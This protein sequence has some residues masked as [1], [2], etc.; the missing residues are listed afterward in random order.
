MLFRS[1]T[2]MQYG[3]TM[4]I[5]TLKDILSLSLAIPLILQGAISLD[6]NSYPNLFTLNSSTEHPRWRD[7]QRE[8]L[9]PYTDLCH[10]SRLCNATVL[11]LT[12][13]EQYT[14][15]VCEVCFCDDLC[16][17]YGDC[18]LDKVLEDT[19]MDKYVN[20]TEPQREPY[21]V[22][23]ADLR[24]KGVQ[25]DEID[26]LAKQRLIF[27]C[28]ENF[29]N[30]SLRS[31]CE[32][33]GAINKNL[34]SLAISSD[35]LTHN[36]PVASTRSRLFYKNRACALCHD[37]AE[38]DTLVP[39]SLKLSCEKSLNIPVSADPFTVLT[40]FLREP[41]CEAV[42]TNPDGIEPRKCA[43]PRDPN[44]KI[45]DQCNTTGKRSVYDDLLWR[46]CNVLSMFIKSYE[47]AY[48][49]PFCLR[50]QTDWM[51]VIRP[52][53]QYSGSVPFF[54]VLSP[55][56]MES[57]QRV[58]ASYDCRCRNGYIYNP[59]KISSELKKAVLGELEQEYN[60]IDVK[61][62]LVHVQ[63]V[64]EIRQNFTAN[65]YAEID[66][67][68][69]KKQEHFEQ[70]LLSLCNQSWIVT[71]PGVN[72]SVSLEPS[73][74]IR[75]NKTFLNSFT[76]D[77][78]LISTKFDDTGL[79]RTEYY[80][81]FPEPVPVAQ[82]GFFA[83]VEEEETIVYTE[84]KN[85][86]MCPHFIYDL[87]N[88]TEIKLERENDFQWPHSND[89]LL[90]L[91][92]GLKL[93][94]NDFSYTDNGLVILC[95]DHITEKM[96]L[97][98]EEDMEDI[99]GIDTFGS[100]LVL[101]SHICLGVSSLCLALTFITYCLFPVLRTLPGKSTMCL[102]LALL[103][104]IGLF[105]SGGFVQASSV[106][107]QIIGVATHFFLLS[108][109]VWMLLCSAHMYSVFSHV[110]EQSAATKSE[111]VSRFRAYI[112]L[113]IAMPASIVLTTVMSN[114]F[115]TDSSPTINTQRVDNIEIDPEETES[116]TNSCDSPSKVRIGY[117]HGICYL[118]NKLSLLLA[119]ALPIAVICA[120][121]LAIFILTLA[122]F[123]R[124]SA[125]EKVARHETRCHLLIYLKLSTLTGINWLP[126]TV[127]A[128]VSSPVVWYSFLIF[129]GLQGLY[130]FL[131]FVCNK[132]VLGLYKQLFTSR[133]NGSVPS[134]KDTK[135]G[136]HAKTQSHEK[137]M[138]AAPCDSKTTNDQETNEQT[139]NSRA[140]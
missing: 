27:K 43:F 101:T 139:H 124:M 98:Y 48:T 107:C 41:T 50:C 49:N 64:T 32:D 109:F 89:I 1:R 37:D 6:I 73:I 71:L 59:Y 131:S 29:G 39:W 45:I 33:F 68:Y 87:K 135:D 95:V 105:I 21:Y 10:K 96:K 61:F 70:R 18:C 2:T 54:I 111:T 38:E 24:V 22:E 108:T 115:L 137:Y 74:Q 46:S 55:D 63:Q 106:E 14:C 30:Q 79:N 47:A 72:E 80:F 94:A 97:D 36:W 40:M 12:S 35:Q 129:C 23:C 7:V 4:H 114:Y 128:F 103:L 66:V 140:E 53:C 130:V 90:H 57:T 82:W 81:L 138:K 20:E 116:V 17:R 34:Y 84:V 69:N 88:S 51:K 65:F 75:P 56:A 117:G 110:M 83:D 78:V 44:L 28:P 86:L 113:S 25:G 92:T 112:A 8:I 85:T 122:A 93:S 5:C 52:S 119:G 121:N 31:E 91:E 133:E 13:S 102:V 104:A 16:E 118:S 127:A 60:S 77:E 58:Q 15:S 126:C 19:L 11:G 125:L 132:R 42:F 99:N 9:T 62:F 76:A 134:T 100:G 136:N 120:A 123:R 3:D 67:S 26:K